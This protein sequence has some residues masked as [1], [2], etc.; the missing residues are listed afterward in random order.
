MGSV[1]SVGSVGRGE[2]WGVWGEIKKYISSPLLCRTTKK[3]C[4]NFT[5]ER[6]KFLL[7]GIVCFI[8]LFLWGLNLIL[9]R[10][11]LGSIMLDI[12]ES[13]RDASAIFWTDVE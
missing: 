1:G 2:V 8:P 13:D 6:K 3:F 12:Y 9:A 5:M 7:I 4:D 11:Y 10:G